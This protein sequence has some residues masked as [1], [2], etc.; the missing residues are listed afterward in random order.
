MKKALKIKTPCRENWEEMTE[1]ETG[2][3]CQKCEKDVVDFSEMTS[4]EILQF[5]R[6]NTGKVCGRIRKGQ[7]REFNRRYQ[8]FPS[9]SN[10]LKWALAAAL[11]GVM[12]YPVY[13]STIDLSNNFPKI[14]LNDLS[15]EN[16]ISEDRSVYKKDSV[17][18]SGQ[19]INHFKDKVPGAKIFIIN[20]DLHC[21]SDENG[22]FS[23]KVPAGKKEIVLR[24]SIVFNNQIS[25]LKVIPSKSVDKLIFVLNNDYHDELMG[26]VEVDFN[27]EHVEEIKN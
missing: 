20:S 10:I 13:A 1:S 6:Q 24:A 19:V 23:M 25:E 16:T 3:F 26:D 22:K 9:S 11:A 8:E 17:I 14:E 15:T 21:Y 18:L 5:F 4:E 7:L 12:A 27:I 2:R